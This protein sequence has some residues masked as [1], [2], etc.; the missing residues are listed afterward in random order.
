RPRSSTRCDRFPN[1][2]A[3]SRGPARRRREHDPVRPDSPDLRREG[4]ARLSE[5]RPATVVRVGT[6]T[7]QAEAAVA[8]LVVRYLER[9]HPGT[10]WRL[11]ERGQGGGDG[12]SATGET[13]RS[14]PARVE[15]E[16]PVARE[17][18]NVELSGE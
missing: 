15:D 9:K 12:E 18:E 10:H 1:S 7:P 8:A 11:R 17:A 2:M 3:R 14:E 13:G 5:D 6:S 16:R 4:A